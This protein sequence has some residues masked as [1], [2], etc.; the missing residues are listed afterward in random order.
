MHGKQKP[1]GAS[2]QCAPVGFRLPGLPNRPALV[3]WVSQ[4][5]PLRYP[6]QPAVGNAAEIDEIASAICLWVAQEMKH[7]GRAWRLTPV[8]WPRRVSSGGSVLMSFPDPGAGVVQPGPMGSP[9][10][11]TKGA[12]GSYG[13]E[14]SRRAPRD[15]RGLQGRARCGPATRLAR[16]NPP[17]RPCA[18]ASG[19]S[20][21]FDAFGAFGTF[22]FAARLPDQTERNARRAGA[23]EAGGVAPARARRGLRCRVP[24][25]GPDAAA[26]TVGE[27]PALAPRG[28]SVLCPDRRLRKA[29]A[30]KYATA[31]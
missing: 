22:G 26:R 18:G 11:G 25:R 21:S 29:T 15:A 19:A 14:S 27:G 12:T 3:S 6:G 7:T 2:P 31:G 10:G 5:A 16:R 24:V 9:G 13:P 17:A 23:P 8:T 4:I 20:G 1:V 28:R 30:P